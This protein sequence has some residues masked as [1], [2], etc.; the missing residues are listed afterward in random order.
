MHEHVGQRLDRNL[1]E[2]IGLSNEHIS[3]HCTYNY[4]DIRYRYKDAFSIS[5]KEIVTND[6]PESIM[7]FQTNIADEF[8]AMSFKPSQSL[9]QY[10]TDI[11]GFI[12][13]CL[14]TE[15]SALSG[16]SRFIFYI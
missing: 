3:H 14:R 15:D 10:E 13:F 6:L 16:P 9:L 11:L 4:F 8:D 12:N 7:S 5:C 1:S 2:G